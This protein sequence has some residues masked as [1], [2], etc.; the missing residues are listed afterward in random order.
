MGGFGCRSGVCSA[1]RRM[2]STEP[3]RIFKDLDAHGLLA[4]HAFGLP[5]L[6]IAVISWPLWQ[7]IAKGIEIS[8]LDLFAL[9]IYFSLPRATDTN[10][11]S[12]LNGVL[13]FGGSPLGISSAG[14]LCGSIL[15]LATWADLFD[16]RRRHESMCRRSRCTII[17]EGDGD[18][19]VPAGLR[20]IWQRFGLGVIQTS[21]TFGHQN[22]LGLVSYFVTLPFFAL[23]LAGQRGWQPAVTPLAG[24]IIAV[25]TASRATLGLTGIGFVAVFVLSALRRWT[26]RKALVSLVGAIAIAVLIPLGLSSLERRFTV[27]PIS[28]DYD[29]RAA[30]EKAAAMILVDHPMGI[31]ANNYV[32]IANTHGYL[33]RAGVTPTRGSRSAPV[34]N[35]ILAGRR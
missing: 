35:I 7:G 15:R 2:A 32:L 5:Q 8:A 31:G 11:I 17:A 28:D 10:S 4:L 19:L 13:F 3:A 30:F 20:R 1:S 34:H 6:D 12:T 33:D 14:T 25:L 18:R 16:L 29:E 26:H 24:A 27:A 9:S 21:G 23:L 22:S